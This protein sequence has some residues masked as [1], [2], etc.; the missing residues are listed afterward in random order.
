MVE[1]HY[2]SMN[3][4]QSNIIMASSN[5]RIELRIAKSN[6][7]YSTFA[8]TGDVI[9]YTRQSNKLILQSGDQHGALVIA[10]N[11]NVGIGRSVPS[12]NLDV[13]GNAYISDTL[14]V[15][16]KLLVGGSHL[17]VNQTSNIVAIDTNLLYAD[18][19]NNRI[20]LSGL[21]DTSYNNTLRNST[22]VEN[23]TTPN[24]INASSITLSGFTP[25]VISSNQKIT[26]LN[27]DLL[28][29]LDSTKFMRTDGD[30]STSG[31]VTATRFLS[32]VAM[33]TPPLNVASS[34][35]VVNLNADLLDGLDSS[36]FL[37]VSNVNTG[38]LPV[39][40]GGIGTQLLTSNKILVGNGTNPILS[41]SN[42]SWSNNQLDISGNLRINDID[43]YGNLFQ[44]GE[45]YISSQWRDSSELPGQ[46]ID[47]SNNKLYY[48][49]GYVGIGTNVPQEMLDVSGNFKIRGHILPA[50][51]VAYDLGSAS[52][53]F[54]DLYL[55]GTS[56]DLGG[57]LIKYNTVTNTVG[58][59]DQQSNP[60]ITS[61]KDVVTT[62]NI[63]V[64]GDLTVNGTYTTVNTETIVIKDPV[65]TLGGYQTLT[66]NDNKDRGVE[67]KYF[68]GSSKVGFFGY[69]N[70]TGNLVYLLD[71]TNN[72]EVFSGTYGNIRANSFVGDTFISSS[73]GV[74]ANFNADLLDG[75]H[76]SYYNDW[77]NLT[78]KPNFVNTFNGRTGDVSLN[79][80]DIN[81]ALTYIPLNA[82]TYTASDVLNKLITVD[83]S[84]SQLDADYLDGYDGSF[85]RNAT[86]I[87]SGILS[88]TYGGIGVNNLSTNKLLIGNATNGILSPNELTWVNGQLD[89]SGNL[90]AND[91]DFYGNLYKNGSLYISS[92]WIDG[93]NN[94]LYYN[95]GNVGINTTNPTQTLDISGTMI[96]NNFIVRDEWFIAN[97]TPFTRTRLQVQPIHKTFIVPTNNV[98]T[99]DVSMNGRFT[100]GHP[101]DVYVFVDGVKLGYYDA[102]NNDYTVTMNIQSTYV[103]FTIVLKQAVN[104]NNIVD[105]DIYPKFLTDDATKEPGYVYQVINSPWDISG[106]VTYY[107]AGNVGIGSSNAS[108]QLDVSGNVYVSGIL[109]AANI[110]SPQFISS[111]VSG[112]PFVV[113]STGLVSNLNADLLDSQE[114]SFYRNASN[115]NSGILSVTYGGIGVNNLST[116]KLLIG[117]ATNGILSPNE[118]TWV[119]SQLDISGN[120]KANDI[121]FYGNLYQNGSLYISSQWTS[122]GSKLYYNSG[123]V[124]IGTNNP[125]EAL[126]V[127]GNIKVK[128]HILP[129]DNV[130]Y[131][132]GSS[133][134]RFRDL[135]LSGS[136]ID[137]SGALIKLDASNNGI[138]FVDS[139]NNPIVTSMKDV[140]TSG[141]VTVGGDLTV[142][143]SFTTVNTDTVTIKD[144]IITLG[145]YQTLTLN[146][147]KDRGVEFRYFDGSS[148]VGFF[149][150]DNDTGNLVYLLDASN[151]NEVFS[152]T[153]GN[154]RANAFIGESFSV[155]SS[156]FV[157]N[158]NADLL[159]GQHGSYYNDWTNLTNKP[160]LVNTFNGRVG[161]VS[162]NAT[163]ISTALTY[164]PLNAATYTASDVLNK[165]IT[166]DGSGSQLDADYLDGYDGTFY[167]NATNINSGV[168]SV[169]YGGI[170]VNNL[171]TNKLLIGNATSGILSP[172]ELT[173]VNGQ[174]DISGN[175]KAND[176]DFYGNLYQNG[177]LYIS[178]Q[179]TSL[180]SELYYNLGNVGINTSN[181]TQT[182]DI[183]GT[184]IVNN[185][186]VRDE[187]FIANDT[188]Y[189]RTQLQV[190]GISNTFVITDA[191]ENSFDISMNGRY[192]LDNPSNV[193][194]HVDGIKLGYYDASNNDYT[195]TTNY[196]TE[197]TYF[198]IVL[199]EP[200]ITGNVVDIVVYPRFLTEDA[201]K[202]PGYVYQVINSPW[203]ISNNVTYY[204]DGNVGI[205]SLNPS[206]Q[207]DV[208]GNVF[209]SGI[210]TAANISGNT[211][212]ASQ[213]AVARK[214]A[215]QGDVSGNVLFSGAADVTITTTIQPN[216]VELGV[217]TFGN[218]V[219]NISSGTDISVSGS[220]TENATV[221]V[222]NTSTLQSVTARGNTTTNSISSPQFIS[223]SV[224][225]A[226]FV[227]SS[228]GLVSNLNVD[229]LDGQDGSFYRNATNIN[230]GILSVTYGGIGVNNLST[231][232][233][234]IGNATNGILSPNEL[235]W[236]NNQL[237]IS[238]NLKANDIDFYGNLYQ[239]GSLY[240]SSQW[241]SLGSELYYNIGYVGIGTNDPQEVLDVSGNI[242][243]KGHI[244]PADN[245][246]YDLG[247][248]SKRF[249]DLYLSGSTIDIS[250]ALIK[251][252]VSN[253]GIRF[254]DSAN[255]PIITSMKDVIT[256]GN[257]TVGGDLTVNGSF[258][259]VNTD[260]VTIKDPIIT[261][262]GYQTL[263]FNDNKDRG[264]EF[265]YFDG[266]S[267]VGFFGYDNDTGNL[268][269]LLDASN[270]NEV[271]SGT[272]GNIRA[273]A[274]IGE[275]FSV[276]SSGFVS[277]LNAD[278]LDGQHGS[279]YND[280]TNL[281][282]KPNLVNTFNGR[283]GDVSLN[284]TDISTALTY[285]PLNAATYTASD[286][287][288]KLI[289]VDGSGSQLDADY[290]D[291]YDG[292]FYRNATNIN[293]GVLS[294]TYGGIGVNNLS[295]NK[296]LIGNA[297]NGIL[298][299]NELTWVNGQ[300]DISGNLKAND[301]DFYGNLYQNGSLYISSQWTDGSDNKLYYNLG[302]VGINTSNP[303]Q[304]LDISGTMIVNNFIVRDEWFIAND[305]PFTRTRLQVQPIHK[306]FIISTNNVTTFDVSM[307]GRFT[308]GHPSDVYVFVDG[309][310]LGYYDASNNDYTVTTNIQSTYVTF[311]IVLKQAVNVNNIVDID[312]YPKFLSEDAT[313]EPGYVYQVINSPWDV[314]G[315]VTYYN[316]GSVGIGSLNP[317]TQLDVSGN[318]FV[319]GILT[320]AN[321]SGNTSTAS[322]L[323]VAR[324]IALQGDVSGN[325]LF[326]GAAD[327]TITT[328]IQPNSVELGV[329]TFG[330][331]VSNISSGTDISVSGSGTENATVTVNNTSTLQSV[332]ARGNT[333]TNSISSPQFISSSVSGAPFVVSSTGL[334]SNLNADLL[335]GQDGSF[336]RNATNINSGI[337]S[338][339][340]G[341]IGVNNLS[342]NKLLIGNATNGIL[343]PNELTWLN[344]QLDISGNL[345]AND[346]DFYG[347]LY[348]N[349]SLYISSQWTS[350]G[351]KLYYNNGYVGIGTNDPQ[352]V[353]DVS[354]NIKIKGHILPADNVAYDLGS[355]SKRFRDLYLSGS[356]IDISGALIKL[357]ASNN[358]IRFVDSANNPIVTSM[359]DVVTSGNVTVGGDLTV[360]GT[361]T[362]VN[363]D[364]VTIKDP[365][366][367]LG[368]YQTLTFN[369]NK[370][371]GVE[372]RYFDGSSK[373]GF[374]GYDNDTGNLVYLLDASNNN[375]VFSGTYGNIRANAFIGESFSVTSSG[376]VSNLNADFLDGQ[377]GSYY[378]D[379]TNLT[380]KPNL[381]N[382]FNGR[383]GDVS[384][385]ATDI[386]TALMYVPL[387]ATTYTA[388]DVLN[389]LKTVDGS[390]SQL[391]AD[392]LD[393]YDGSYYK[394]IDNVNSGVLSVMYGG[395]GNNV[396]NEGK[397]LV[398]NGTNPVL[399]PTDL[400][401]DGTRL[402]IGTDTPQS[403]LHF[404]DTLL[405]ETGNIKF[406]M[407]QYG[408]VF[409][410]QGNGKYIGYRLL[411]DTVGSRKKEIKIKGSGH[412]TGAVIGFIRF[413]VLIDTLDDGVLKPGKFQELECYARQASNINNLV[414]SISRYSDKGVD[415]RVVWDNLTTDAHA[416]LQLEVISPLGYVSFLEIHN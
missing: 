146:D 230:S 415:V 172:N 250:G 215:L 206:S 392:Y 205:G 78:N 87:N 402:G 204:N 165:L 277:N 389:K 156:G 369:D 346:I 365:I 100:L 13:S 183:S 387:D 20:S 385:N 112:A 60:I 257:V 401:W 386:S 412:I 239:N 219:S 237:D 16:N 377:H 88:V 39:S 21:P 404:M 133:S 299:P 208:S 396:L 337:L 254:V 42:L 379:W 382:T 324:K 131:D 138:R 397:L 234:L 291:G 416:T 62:G 180:G 126:D 290:L 275:S 212:T 195:V 177:S 61:M 79:A 361:F 367:T 69:D 117:N 196:Q 283:T 110:F 307:N 86:N 127:S 5:D 408:D 36:Y 348:Q 264:V 119:N 340:Y 304:T 256:S 245:V 85:Y 193:H 194:V 248:S 235:T 120:L 315:N 202:E 236:V 296:L 11:N 122:L 46:S 81:T 276:T 281:T 243:I 164:V 35:K 109:T 75:Q 241:T 343:S 376:V 144:P 218:Y 186:I 221:T 251:L 45:L 151:N 76:G 199:T 27:A 373:V 82:A 313:K 326:S 332:T 246:A 188:P 368:G 292:T 286:V 325:V 70:D 191:S 23:L 104:V 73:T 278:L 173:W 227:V 31:S 268:V 229:L 357:D 342:T 121:D 190:N 271:F 334:V 331:Y 284:A 33:G 398:G 285:V 399:S 29:G 253:N 302:N 211:S 411:W 181:P 265:R 184:M 363:T 150:Y 40:F 366:I 113:A 30:T 238:G 293:S 258:T 322:Q 26:N 370:D 185:F 338:V 242:K 19:S 403:R 51:N 63:T 145:G 94:E 136:T 201:T 171:S 157:S 279:Y 388:S 98:T 148:K 220:G 330:N 316:D 44:N 341:G 255:N 350:L 244:L 214:I 213:L 58:F 14:I 339:T 140:I 24:N 289:T 160:N 391:D 38:T 261:L 335:D 360:N 162:L 161:D 170:G 192:R 273:N 354:G 282:N 358:G 93:S 153:Y 34:T 72:G 349:G 83:G 154:I 353:L 305:T 49:V 318:V 92:Q 168:L 309:V 174:L 103:T 320:A 64:G 41:P 395:T 355:S 90:K 7:Q 327:V 114:G 10:A 43:F 266:S 106:N 105:I 152:G 384:L 351:S 89:I 6:N 259:T 55:S 57:A 260:T 141:N 71:A 400:T 197:N 262:G 280:W 1:T 91:I 311:T 295:T 414:Y 159:D 347:N 9:I 413:E 99:F 222:N 210:L 135:Y 50:D 359:K 37:N 267:K 32:N 8:N 372:F 374:F 111:S 4:F 68:N 142:N 383:V 263:T 179:W 56:I 409:Y 118:L 163:D 80:T 2:I 216:S 247:S 336:Y 28:D 231:N 364:T 323:A 390:G 12:Y 294:V 116:N 17:T 270:N 287:L 143:G 319:S 132:L 167:R 125:Q 321:I 169:T 269:Y 15:P 54:K 189:I 298:S 101:S 228:T 176:I 380:N 308:L 252:D 217:D 306:T 67:F 3:Y 405:Q 187:W 108:A 129:T 375:E 297:T 356:T 232:K 47:P 137:I 303:T 310:K 209:I 102:S 233:L 410:N 134:K 344:N 300:L 207:L 96:V 149:G 240:I 77:T 328:T 224:S 18:C 74:V 158:L 329:D 394:N 25:I 393:G 352:E 155:T 97:D 115:I 345:K 317:S 22:L 147:N 362:T 107:N 123:Y 274:F 52:Q 314:S 66:L 175:L 182:L 407:K 166:V 178:S 333:T 378:N 223:S 128:G 139:A 226:P 65:I 371:R 84:G 198:T 53:R 312:I 200:V 272:Y 301:I 406:Y 225:G 95:L 59:F 288:N 130:A 203:D 124:G 381:V 48:D 249:R